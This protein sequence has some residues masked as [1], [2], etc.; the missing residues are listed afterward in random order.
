MG[1]RSLLPIFFEEPV[2]QKGS[3]QTEMLK[4]VSAFDLTAGDG[5]VKLLP[6]MGENY[7]VSRQMRQRQSR[8]ISAW[9]T[10]ARKRF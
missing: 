4:Q 9:Y 5:K 7:V 6:P 8:L 10:T 2:L 3:K 1:S